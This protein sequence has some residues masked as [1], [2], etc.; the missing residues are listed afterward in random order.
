MPGCPVVH[1]LDPRVCRQ[2]HAQ[3]GS[4]CAPPLHRPVLAG[5]R[6]RPRRNLL[7]KYP[8]FP[9]VRAALTA[10]LWAEGNGGEAEANWFRVEDPRCSPSPAVVAAGS[11]A[12]GAASG[13]AAG[14][15]GDLRLLQAA[16]GTRPAHARLAAA[17]Q[18]LAMGGLRPSG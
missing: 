14:L 1:W 16:A 13:R 7:R 3:L 4:S 17:L 15:P 8:D 11:A 18:V 12:A 6:G 5:E 9:D 10:A 2:G